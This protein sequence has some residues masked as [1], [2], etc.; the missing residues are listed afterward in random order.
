MRKKIGCMALICCFSFL[1]AD[2]PESLPGY[3]A[4]ELPKTVDAEYLAIAPAHSHH[5][6]FTYQDGIATINTNLYA[7]STSELG[8]QA[9][10]RNIYMKLASH[11]HQR[12]TVYGVVNLNGRY[13]GVERWVWDGGLAIQP[14]LNANTFE[15]TRYIGYLHGRFLYNEVAGLHVGAYVETGMRTANVKPIIGADYTQGVWTYQLVY[16][17]KA[18]VSYGGIEKNLLSLFMRPFYTAERLQKGPYHHRSV[19]KFAADG[20]EF[21]WDWMP[22]PRWNAWALVGKTVM[23]SLTI[24]DHHFHH[25]HHMHLQSAPYLQLGLLY[26]F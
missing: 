6:K 22:S 25:R 26:Q 10:F 7:S 5:G 19:A 24:G 3:R 16:P 23:S 2:E 18:G 13:S 14:N 21:R 11:L 20:I 17:L 12:D 4:T 8:L 15:S 9:G 1:T